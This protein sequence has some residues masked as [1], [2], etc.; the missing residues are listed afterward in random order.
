ME[1]SIT[2]ISWN[3]LIAVDQENVHTLKYNNNIIFPYI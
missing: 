1:R 2:A 3:Y